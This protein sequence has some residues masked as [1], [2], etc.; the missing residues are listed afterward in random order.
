MLINDKMF[1]M[2]DVITTM[3]ERIAGRFAIFRNNKKYRLLQ[4][5]CKK[6]KEYLSTND[7]I[8]FDES[9]W[10]RLVLPEKRILTGIY[11]LI[12]K[13]FLSYTKWVEYTYKLY[14]NR[15]TRKFAK[16]LFTTPIPKDFEVW[17]YDNISGRMYAP[18]GSEIPYLHFLFFKITKYLETDK[19]WKGDYWMLQNYGLDNLRKILFSL[20]G[21]VGKQ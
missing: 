13:H 6:W 15:Y 2:Y 17:E 16:E 7:H 11:K 10:V 18:N 9:D 21:V 5:R 8:G 14:S 12:F 4:F 1:E 20:N 3:S 19:Y